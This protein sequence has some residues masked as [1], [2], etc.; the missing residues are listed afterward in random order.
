M[1]SYRMYLHVA[2][3]AHICKICICQIPIDQLWER[4]KYVC[5]RSKDVTDLAK[6]RKM[7]IVCEFIQ[8][9]KDINYTYEGKSLVHIGNS[10]NYE[11]TQGTL[12]ALVSTSSTIRGLLY[13]AISSCCSLSILSNCSIMSSSLT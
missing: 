1:H 13:L 6:K 8:E 5:S 11:S 2:E 9:S 7:W 3:Y 4:G 10:G 12:L